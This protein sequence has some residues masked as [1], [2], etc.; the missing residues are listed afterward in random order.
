[1]GLANEI[2]GIRGKSRVPVFLFSFL[3]G[4][5]MTRIRIST[6]KEPYLVAKV[7]AKK[8]PPKIRIAEF[9]GTILDIR[10]K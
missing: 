6:K 8:N 1:M 9:R 2:T 10:Y 7:V 3:Y 5:D 4:C